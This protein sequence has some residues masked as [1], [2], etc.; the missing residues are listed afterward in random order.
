MSGVVMLLCTTRLISLLSRRDI[1]WFFR[2]GSILLFLTFCPIASVFPP[3]VVSFP[4]CTLAKSRKADGHAAANSQFPVICISL[5]CDHVIQAVSKSNI[6]DWFL[7]SLRLAQVDSLSTTPAAHAHF[8]SF[9]SPITKWAACKEVLCLLLPPEFNSNSLRCRC[10][11]MRVDEI[12]VPCEPPHP[13]LQPTADNPSRHP[14]VHASNLGAR[15]FCADR[16]HASIF[17][18]W[19]TA[20][21]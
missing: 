21:E 13:T 9:F 1:G 14:V 10:L 8:G 16:N 20:V 4:M 5:A 17:L 3:P 19:S 2:T 6:D 12:H 15:D 7:S 11:C 18:T